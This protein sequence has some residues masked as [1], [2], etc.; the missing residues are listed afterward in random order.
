MD[1]EYWQGRSFTTTLHNIYVKHTDL[2]GTYKGVDMVAIDI[3]PNRHMN[4]ISN[5]LP[6]STIINQFIQYINKMWQWHCRCQ[7]SLFVKTVLAFSFSPIIEK[8]EE[9]TIFMTSLDELVTSLI[10]VINVLDELVY[11][12]LPG[13]AVPFIW[14]QMTYQTAQLLSNTTF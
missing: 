14:L 4:S 2:I 10:H 5:V 11:D 8:D 13:I 7:N 9:T 1:A 6:C 3:P 12:S